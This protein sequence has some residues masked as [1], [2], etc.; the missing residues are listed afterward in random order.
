MSQ[1]PFSEAINQLKPKE[2]QPRSA[3]VLDGWVAQAQQILGGQ[4]SG[5]RLG[6]LIASTVVV[7]ALQRAVDEAGPLFLLK[8][9]TLLQHRL[10]LDARATSDID[11]LVRGDLTRFLVVLDEVI[12]EPWGPLGIERG[13]VEYIKTPP[14]ITKPMRFSVKVR[15]GTTTWRR[16]QVEVA[17]DEGGAEDSS[18]VVIPP[19]LA[20]FGLPSPE[21]LATLALR[22]QIAQKLHACTDPHDPP[23]SINDRPR[24]VVDLLLL[25]DLVG[26]EGRPTLLE[27]RVAAE[28]IFAARAADARALGRTERTWPCVAVAHEHWRADFAAA[29]A[30]SYVNITLQEG[31][32]RGQLVGRPDRGS[33]GDP[34]S[35]ARESGS[36]RQR[37]GA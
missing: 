16:V 11:G 2:K 3:R 1:S 27:L 36:I 17:S 24:D 30:G 37:C 13:P 23:A 14:R 9:G 19:S 31:R 20:G 33:H 15:V 22:F 10:G 4:I 7:A 26:T 29:R 32:R 5:G 18:E 34:A 25:R 6:W 35:W 21:T 28:A 12:K 8:G